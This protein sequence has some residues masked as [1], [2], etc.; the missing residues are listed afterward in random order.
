[1]VVRCP[2]H[3]DPEDPVGTQCTKAMVFRD[4]A[5]QHTA[6]MLLRQWCLEGRNFQHRARTDAKSSSHRWCEPRSLTPLPEA[7]QDELLA[8]GLAAPSWI[9]DTGA[10]SD[11]SEMGSE[12]D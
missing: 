11:S 4:Q 10:E 2:H 9:K 8:A 12:A 5:E 7:A 6:K 3:K 1:M